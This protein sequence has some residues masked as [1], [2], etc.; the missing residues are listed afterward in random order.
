MIMKSRT[1]E[2]KVASIAP[3]G[4]RMQPE[5]KQQIEEQAR[6]NGRSLNA[7]IVWRL[8]QSLLDAGSKQ[9][10]IKKAKHSAVQPSIIEDRLLLLEEQ[11]SAMKES[12]DALLH[13][14]QGRLGEL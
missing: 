4:V 6:T 8:E 5:L 13:E 10:W 14:R 2:R 1:P 11:L 12:V 9:G 3:F 7:E